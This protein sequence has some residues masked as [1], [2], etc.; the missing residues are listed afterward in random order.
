ML[1][2]LEGRSPEACPAEQQPKPGTGICT[3]RMV[4][5]H[6]RTLRVS[7]QASRFV[8]WDRIP[9]SAESSV[10]GRTRPLRAAARDAP[11]S[12]LVVS[13]TTGVAASRRRSR[14][15]APL[16]G[17]GAPAG[18]ASAVHAARGRNGLRTTDLVGVPLPHWPPAPLLETLSP[19]T[20]QR[21]EGLTVVA[22][23]AGARAGQ[24]LLR[25]SQTS[26]PPP[27]PSSLA[28]ATIR[29]SRPS[30]LRSTSWMS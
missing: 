30:P 24:I 17:P 15:V 20:R 5:S 19:P 21:I 11:L 14:H 12:A 1:T 13:V 27:S 10:P 9:A 22:C 18:S 16:R 4:G 26:T 7:E 3:A 8:G 29:S 28:K 25:L 2:S 6:P 23:R